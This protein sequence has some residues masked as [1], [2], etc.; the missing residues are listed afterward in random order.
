MHARVLQY[1]PSTKHNTGSTGRV[2]RLLASEYW[3]GIV[4]VNWVYEYWRARTV[5][6]VRYCFEMIAQKI[7]L[8]VIRDYFHEEHWETYFQFKTEFH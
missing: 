7:T 2:S 5:R 3:Q 4:E 6:N 1:T 8:V